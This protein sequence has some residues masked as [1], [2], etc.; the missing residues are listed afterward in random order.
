MFL[1]NSTVMF[2]DLDKIILIEDLE[3]GRY[4][5]TLSDTQY[6]LYTDKPEA[7]AILAGLEGKET[8]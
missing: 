3:T 4:R 8:K 5:I 6:P 1:K 7:L 2:I